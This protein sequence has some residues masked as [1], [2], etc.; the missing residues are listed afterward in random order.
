MMQA[1]EDILGAVEGLPAVR[2]DIDDN[3]RPAGVRVG[4]R[5]VAR[6]DLRRGSV[7][8]SAA[9]ERIPALRRRFSSSRRTANGI[10]FDL[11]DAEDRSEALAAIRRRVNVER[12]AP[13]LRVASP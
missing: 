3:Q 13:H 10:V 5:V 12:L 1:V 6:I 9:A 11:T 2:L 8:V 4:A 7:L